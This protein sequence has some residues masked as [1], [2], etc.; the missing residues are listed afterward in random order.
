M[1]TYLTF[2]SLPHY[3]PARQAALARNQRLRFHSRAHALL[4]AKRLKVGTRKTNPSFSLSRTHTRGHLS[5]H[6]ITREFR[7]Y[8][9]SISKESSCIARQHRRKFPRIGSPPIHI[10]T[11]YIHAT[12]EREGCMH[13]HVTHSCTALL[14]SRCTHRDGVD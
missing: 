10:H 11:K 14:Y 1:Y 4:S 13:A 8:H 7:H 5:G 9:K 12:R 3:Y 6:A 2:C